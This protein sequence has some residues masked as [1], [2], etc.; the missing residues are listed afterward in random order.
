MNIE[1]ECHECGDT[2]DAEASV[3]RDGT[4]TLDVQPCK[5]CIDKAKDEGITEGTRDGYEDGHNA[6]H[7]EGYELGYKDGLEEGKDAGRPV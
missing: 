7:D 3:G 5:T 1:C 6:G 2:L 4:I